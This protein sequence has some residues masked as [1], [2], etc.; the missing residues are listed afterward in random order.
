M[1]V[2]RATWDRL[3]GLDAS[4]FLYCE[5]L[6]LGLRIW[7]A[8]ERVGVVPAAQVVHSYEFDKGSEKWFWLERNRL[9]TVL[10]VYPP[11]LLLLLTPA[12]LAAEVALLAV[13]AGQ[14]WL[15]A[16]LRAQAAVLTGLPRTLARRQTV[17]ATRRL[18][19][20]QFATHLTA[21]LDSEFLPLAQ[22]GL[23][24]RI[25]RAYW[26]LVRGMLAAGR[27]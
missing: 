9:R 18:T 16:K 25:Q 8:G 20:R 26:A 3:G 19:A 21:S 12:L 13:A 23:P 15:G 27:R 14:G 17:Q 1:V 6:D 2:R 7:L 10:S 24:A 11:A 4:Y 5:D 22:D